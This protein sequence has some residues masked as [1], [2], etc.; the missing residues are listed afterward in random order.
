MH[1]TATP[2]TKKKQILCGVN[3]LII[4]A[5]SLSFMRINANLSQ[6]T[7]T[8]ALMMTDLIQFAF[9]L[10]LLMFAFML[11]AHAM[12]GNTLEM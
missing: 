4:L 12:F 3:C 10:L 8:L 6:L 9:V 5:V 2:P 11:M 1:L 7:D